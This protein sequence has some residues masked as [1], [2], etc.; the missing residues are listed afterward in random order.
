MKNE[1]KKKSKVWL[2]LWLLLAIVAIVFGISLFMILREV[3]FL[4][5]QSDSL[6]EELR[7]IARAEVT[8]SEDTSSKDEEDEEAE[9]ESDVD[10]KA[11]RKVN[12]DIVGWIQVPNTVIDYP[13][14]QSSEDDPEY[15]LYRDYKRQDTK[16]GSVFLNA[17][18]SVDLSERNSKCMTLYGHH[19]NDG[20]MFAAILQFADLDFYCTTPT[21]TFD[22]YEST[23]DWKIISVFKTNIRSDQ[24]EVFEYVRPDFADD[25]DFLN[26][27]Y[28]VRIRSIIDTPVT[29]NE[30]DQLV[31]LSTCSYEYD[32]F[33]TV[34]VARKVRDGESTAVNTKKASYNSAPLYPDC[35]Y[36]SG[37][38]KPSYPETFAKALKKG[39]VDWYDGTLFD[40]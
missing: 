18:N 37:G 29:V 38:S 8:T 19:M 1:A 10:F 24:G 25:E 36:S 12:S 17:L 6:N 40:T 30:D 14:L 11:L 28:Q 9:R 27:V 5:A 39:V 16:Y 32:D 33:R 21:F 4:P 31:V 7:T 35:W 13:V 22:T 20:R 3:V 26:F 23:G 34:V 15:Y 2:W